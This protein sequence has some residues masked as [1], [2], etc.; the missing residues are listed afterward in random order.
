[1]LLRLWSVWGSW[2][3]QRQ[4]GGR[5]HSTMVC[6]LLLRMLHSLKRLTCS[7]VLDISKVHESKASSEKKFFL[8]SAAGFSF[9]VFR[10]LRLFGSTFWHCKNLLKKSFTHN[11]T[12]Y[13]SVGD[14]F[15]WIMMQLFPC[16]YSC[17]S[18]TGQ[19]QDTLDFHIITKAF[20]VENQWP[21]SQRGWTAT[22]VPSHRPSLHN[23][24]IDV[25][26][27]F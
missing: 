22:R 25:L 13:Y 12:Y 9:S 3:A 27:L 2:S 10:T 21:P 14:S 11:V 16:N 7:K 4:T 18:R 15:L 1:M 6:H 5:C 23:W 8:G 20:D 24:L 17:P 26:Y 19:L